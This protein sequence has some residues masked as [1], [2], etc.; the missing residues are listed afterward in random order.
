M[1]DKGTLACM[2]VYDDI[3]RAMEYFKATAETKAA[4]GLSTKVMIRQVS[5]GS[6]ADLRA[7]IGQ[8]WPQQVRERLL[9]DPSANPFLSMSTVRWMG[10]YR[11]P[12]S[13]IWRSG[14]SDG[15]QD[16]FIPR[17]LCLAQLCGIDQVNL[18]D[19][20]EL[21]LHAPYYEK[22]ARGFVAAMIG[23]ID[24]SV[25][26]NLAFGNI[27]NGRPVG[28]TQNVESNFAAVA[29]TMTGRMVQ[30]GFIQNKKLVVTYPKSLDELEAVGV[31]FS[32]PGASNVQEGEPVYMLSGWAEAMAFRPVHPPGTN[33]LSADQRLIRY[34][35]HGSPLYHTSS[36][37]SVTIKR[38][39]DNRLIAKPSAF[40]I[41]KTPK[42][43]GQGVFG[44]PC[45]CTTAIA[46]RRLDAGDSVVLNGVTVE[47]F[48]PVITNKLRG[49]DLQ[50]HNLSLWW[51]AD[52]VLMQIYDADFMM[53][54][55]YIQV[56]GECF[57]CAVNR[58]FGTG[59]NFMVAGGLSDPNGIWLRKA[60]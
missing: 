20:L 41:T 54:S 49:P 47:K 24:K 51:E 32:I 43:T 29:P 35:V 39:A 17:L 12:A 6:V 21:A 30:I 28:S 7:R 8:R 14:L 4:I 36:Q 59:C 1:T 42:V 5:Q 40:G 15:F 26:S 13:L 11:L 55:H 33:L 37:F 22:I 52:D 31:K 50:Y 44:K 48:K 2:T 25:I 38:V 53:Y 27:V 10:K 18:V 19:L 3:W 57:Y 46:G 23:N 45:G 16:L 60:P 34:D 58:A 56:P 9:K